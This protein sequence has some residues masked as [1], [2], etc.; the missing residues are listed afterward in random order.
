LSAVMAASYQEPCQIREVA[1]KRRKPTI[2]YCAAQ[3]LLANCW[4]NSPMFGNGTK[5]SARRT[6]LIF[7]GR[8]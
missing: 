2:R 1:E 5:H 7:S 3:N 4:Y 8:D 6:I